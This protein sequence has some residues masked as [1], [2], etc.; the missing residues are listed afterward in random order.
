[1]TQ[2]DHLTRCQQIEFFLARAKAAADTLLVA[3]LTEQL[4]ELP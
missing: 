1:M 2:W 4:Q 3:W